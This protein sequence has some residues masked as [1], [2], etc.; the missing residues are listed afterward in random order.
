MQK[1]NP[2]LQLKAIVLTLYDKRLSLTKS[3]ESVARGRFGKLIPETVIP[4][5]ISI[6]EAT[7]DGEPVGIY[8][9]R[10]TGAAAYKTLTKELFNG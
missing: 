5:N 6:A 1:G 8:A 2:S 3:V 10:S 9:R 4:I 7:L